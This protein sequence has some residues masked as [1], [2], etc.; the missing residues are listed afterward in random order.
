M[1][2][3]NENAEPEGPD[4]SPDPEKALPNPESHE[5]NEFPTG[6]KLFVIMLSNALAM[7]LVALVSIL[8]STFL[9]CF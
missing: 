8:Y 5:K 3:S 9:T 2:P 6:K 7:F 4:V 1:E